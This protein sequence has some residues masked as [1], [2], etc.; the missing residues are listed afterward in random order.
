MFRT[1]RKLKEIDKKISVIL[2]INFIFLII[3][4]I[5]FFIFLQIIAN[6]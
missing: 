6:A 1:Y 5:W 2:V 4:A 3:S